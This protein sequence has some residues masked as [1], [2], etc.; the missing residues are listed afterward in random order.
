M[1][2]N[3]YLN[4][5]Q[6]QSVA[7]EY[8]NFYLSETGQSI[9]SIEKELIMP[10]LKHLP[11]DKMLEL[12]CGTG[13][14]S[15]FF[16]RA[17]FHVTAVDASDA[18]LEIAKK[19]EIKNVVFQKADAGSL[20]FPDR[21]FHSV[22]SITMLEFVEDINR[23]MNEID[24]VLIPGGTLVVGCLNVLSEVG[25]NKDSDAVFKYGRFFTPETV[26]KLLSRFGTPSLSE[27]VYLSPEYKLLDN[28]PLQHTVSP[29]FIA[30]SV[31]KNKNHGNYR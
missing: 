19:K 9:D 4:V 29:V 14:W 30:A 27:G 12:G 15:E 7:A 11:K 26:R 8:D 6:Q 17:G 2:D 20:P 21:Y 22:A 18:M 10:Y 23:V 24:R 16:S 1:P 25:K 13:H 5:F 31:I 28:S 3:K